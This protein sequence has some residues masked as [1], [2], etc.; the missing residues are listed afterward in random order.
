MATVLRTAVGAV[1]VVDMDGRK[2]G[3]GSGHAMSVSLLAAAAAALVV[4]EQQHGLCHI[5]L[6]GLW[7]RELLFLM[8]SVW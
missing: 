8:F 6:Q 3:G 1:G 5:G 7:P 2:G 4:V